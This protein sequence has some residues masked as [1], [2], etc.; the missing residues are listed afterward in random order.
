MSNYKLE[1]KLKQQ[2]PII[3]FQSEQI[4]ATLRATEVKPKLDR[5][6]KKRINVAEHTDWFIGNDPEGALNYKMQIVAKGDPEISDPHKIYY[7][8]MG[9]NKKQAVMWKE[10]ISLTII[11]MIPELRAEINK[12]IA[13]FFIV[14]NFGTMQSKGF[15]SFLI[16]ISNKKYSDKEIA[17]ALKGEYGSEKKI[18]SFFSNDYFSAI[19]TIYSIMKS[20]RNHGGYQRS[21]LFLYMHDRGI[22]NEKAWLKQEGLAP[23]VERD[24]HNYHKNLHEPKYVRALL[25]VGDHIDF[26]NTLGT[27]DNQ[28][29][30]KTEVKISN[31]DIQRL[32]SCILFK[33]INSKVYFVGRDINSDIYEKNFIFTSSSKK[34]KKISN[35]YKRAW[36]P[37]KTEGSL[38]TPKETD[39]DIDDFLNYCVTVLNKGILNKF[40]E[41]RNIRILE[42]G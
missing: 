8:N 1:Y 13:D 23:I 22:G 15:G 32:E 31:D 9:D 21:L 10:D 19:N 18:Y 20:G 28:R 30:D 35:D 29:R 11:C 3:H 26:K 39:F 33:V 24:G 17:C 41:T 27:D 42:V 7:G 4:G 6:I 37:K 34:D 38:S 14:S 5:Y 16:L 40:S 36:V 25:G 2:T 12:H